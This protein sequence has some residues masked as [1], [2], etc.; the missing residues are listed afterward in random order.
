E[1]SA[2]I[3]KVRLAF[4]NFRHLWRGRDIRL[5]TKGHVYCTAVRFVQLYGSETWPVRIEVT[6]IPPW[7]SSKHHSY[8]LGPSSK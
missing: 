4:T 6:N 7:M 1:P 5:S 3:Q 2:R 8:I